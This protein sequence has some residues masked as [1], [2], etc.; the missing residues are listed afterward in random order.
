MKSKW[1]LV[2]HDTSQNHVNVWVGT[3]FPDLRKPAHC[4]V[5]LRDENK[6]EIARQT[7]SRDQ[8]Q[9]PFTQLNCRFF[10]YLTFDNLSENTTYT[11][12]FVRHEQIIG[13]LTLIDKVLSRGQFQTLPEHLSSDSPFVVALGSCFYNEEDEGSAASAYT[14]LFFQD[15]K[16]IKPQVKFLTGDQVYLDIGLDSLSPVPRDIRNRIADDYAGVW[17]IQRSM[18][19]H[20]ATWFLADDHEYWNNFPYTS[21][22][23]PYL[24]MITAF[25]KLKKVWSHT[26]TQG[27][28]R[29]QQVSLIRT[30]DIGNELSFCFADLRSKRDKGEHPVKMIPTRAFKQL[31]DWAKN[32]TS[33][34]V[35]V[36]PQPLLVEPGSYEDFNLLNYKIQYQTLLQALASSGHDIICLSGDVHFGRIASVPLGDNGA[37][38]HEIISSPMSNLTGLDGKVA[39]SKAKKLN[40]FPS[41]EITGINTKA[42]KYPQHW[43]VATQKVRFMWFSS[44]RKTKEHFMTLAFSKENDQVSLKVQAWR[45]REMYKK[46]GLPKAEFAKCHKFLLR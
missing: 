45:V 36:L 27:V 15:N 31:I 10:Q 5:I 23:N 13:E 12:D 2:I 42:V 18:L 16:W 26:A 37:M 33:P 20:G 1:S 44:Y 34:G 41:I 14:N 11:V 29:I 46:T 9:R 39:T 24:W 4:S 32:L 25:D 30:F 43:A 35:I 28:E 8:W 19:R 6:Q 40:T 3:L 21:G 17:Q 22:K 38:L 7:I